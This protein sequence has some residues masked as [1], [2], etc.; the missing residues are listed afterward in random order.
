MGVGCIGIDAQ[1]DGRVGFLGRG[2]ENYFAGAGGQVLGGVF[3]IPEKPGALGGDIDTERFPI[4]FFRVAHG[5]VGDGAP[6]HLNRVFPGNDV[7]IQF[8]VDRVV[9]Q[10]MGHGGCVGEV[11]DGHDLDVFMLQGRPEHQPA[12]SAKSVNTDFDCHMLSPCCGGA[13]VE[14]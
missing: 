12:D 10:K 5:C 6:V 8:A 1:N 7:V 2:G 13:V 9:C 11:I 3:T 14:S 4:Q